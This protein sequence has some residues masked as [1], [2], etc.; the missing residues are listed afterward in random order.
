MSEKLETKS[1][2]FIALKKRHACRGFDSLRAVPDE[3]LDRLVYAA[4]RAS[5]GGGKPYRFL[6]IVRDPN[7]LKM[8]KMVSP[9]LFGNPPFVFAICSW[10]RI[11]SEPLP[12]MDLDEC[13][14]IDAG[15]AAEN[16]VLVAYSLG[17]GACFVKSYSE[18]GVAR[19]LGL[20]PDART[21]LMVSL[22]YPARDEPPFLKKSTSENVTYI[23]KYG[24]KFY[25]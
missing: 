2:L 6:I 24:A 13:T 23:D 4:H 7:Q 14:R 10:T 22:G 21:E 17:L 12:K 25:T 3:I 19:L 15:A 1:D 18:A 20:P 5:T 16:V 8:L 9:G 11:G